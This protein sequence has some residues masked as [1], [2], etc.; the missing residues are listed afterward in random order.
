MKGL[1]RRAVW[2]IV[3]LV[4]I[5]L[6]IFFTSGCWGCLCGCL[7]GS[8]H[9]STAV[10]VTSRD[11]A[12]ES[13]AGVI[14]RYHD[15]SIS[16]ALATTK[17]LQYLRSLAAAPWAIGLLLPTAPGA[18]EPGKLHGNEHQVGFSAWGS[19]SISAPL[20]P[21]AETAAGLT[22]LFPPPAGHA[23]QALKPANY[24]W[25]NSI[26]TRTVTIT[27]GYGQLHYALDF[28]G[29]SGC[30]GC[31]MQLTACTTR[32]L[33]VSERLA[34]Q[35]GAGVQVVSNDAGLTC[36]EP[37][38]STIALVDQS[39]R[40][41]PGRLTSVAFGLWGGPGITTTMTTTVEIP[42]RLEH[43]STSAETYRLEAIESELGFAYAW[44]DAANQPV[45]QITLPPASFVFGPTNL[46]VRAT[47][48]PTC[49]H[50]LDTV[51]ISATHV[52]TP[53]LQ[54]T[55]WFM[56]Q[57]IPDPARCPVADIGV[58]KSAG[59]TTV[60]AGAWL[61]YTLTITNY[62]NRVVSAVISDT[63]QPAYAVAETRLPAGCERQD[64]GVRC[65]VS[66]LP[67]RGARS[68]DIG[69]RVAPNYAGT[70]ENGA[71][72]EP[73]GAIDTRQYDNDAAAPAVDVR[74]TRWPAHL[75]LV[76]K[77]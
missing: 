51:H 3:I 46:R 30:N 45:T 18:T 61:T 12:A 1:D 25:M 69:V 76:K 24:D 66:N 5:A 4:C 2:Q 68:L 34:L 10:S 49:A 42:V 50:Q 29:A 40:M 15:F 53:S 64:A 60:D 27:S 57:L 28:A 73:A 35:A 63:W 70:L 26:P 47:G 11:V 20:I 43:T 41:L 23:W 56:V 54:T 52:T 17:D 58:R 75:P 38:P 14:E 22:E 48:L 8:D 36:I 67:A 71:H 31:N 13:A 44:R 33:S 9:N 19:F 6:G 7:G 72:A 55:N 65:A 16:D 74:R 32:S 77:G 59:A 39:G 62:E 37:K 21:D